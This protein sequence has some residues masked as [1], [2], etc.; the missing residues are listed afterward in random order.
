[1]S[2]ATPFPG[3][4]AQLPNHEELQ[5]HIQE[6]QAA[7][8]RVSDSL[9]RV[10]SLPDNSDLRLHGLSYIDRQLMLAQSNLE[11]SRIA[12]QSIMAIVE[13]LTNDDG[14]AALGGVLSVF[15]TPDGSGR[16]AGGGL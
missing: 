3:I 2:H 7:M 12:V 4:P 10:G 11:A 1:M 6:F 8:F 15:D 13:E 16:N 5:R 9:Q 14:E